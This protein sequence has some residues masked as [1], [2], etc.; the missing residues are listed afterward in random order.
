M[1]KTEL[2]TLFEKALDRREALS[3][4]TLCLFSGE[5]EGLKGLRILRLEDHVF[6]TTPEN[7][8][9]SFLQTLVEVCQD[10]FEPKSF[11]LKT[12]NRQEMLW[13]QDPQRIALVE[14]EH[15]WSYGTATPTLFPLHQKPLRK[16]LSGSL[17][18]KVLHLRENDE[19]LYP[20][21][22]SHEPAHLNWHPPLWAE[23]CDHLRR[24]QDAFDV[25]DVGLLFFRVN[26]K[27]NKGLFH[28][29]FQI[30]KS[31]NPGGEIWLET[32]TP[33]PL[34]KILKTA[35]K[36][37]GRNVFVAEEAPNPPD[38]PKSLNKQVHDIPNYFRILTES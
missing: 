20:D 25:I 15:T 26:E 33:L 24:S 30:L 4:Q 19:F 29:W 13:G 31:L 17:G 9:D 34:F 36:K 28:F 18:K 10:R 5:S 6:C 7:F 8:S 37:T 35:S 12:S 1:K 22:S 2:K 11:W 16:W 32:H 14:N 38:F 23:A 3:G 27:N 21:G